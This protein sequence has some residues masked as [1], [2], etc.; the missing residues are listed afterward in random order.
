MS[1][2]MP[3]MRHWPNPDAPERRWGGKPKP[4]ICTQVSLIF[5]V[6]GRLFSD[7]RERHARKHAALRKEIRPKKIVGPRACARAA[8]RLN[9]LFRVIG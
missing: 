4:N 7:P 3:R 1:S 8:N 2:L 5:S 6:M 9:R